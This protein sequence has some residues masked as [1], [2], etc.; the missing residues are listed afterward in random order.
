[1]SVAVNNW[2]S[3]NFNIKVFPSKKDL[4]DIAQ[5]AIE[6][7][8]KNIKRKGRKL[9][10]SSEVDSF[11]LD[12]MLNEKFYEDSETLNEAMIFFDKLVAETDMGGAFK[13]EEKNTN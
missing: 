3:Y 12:N 10:Y 13:K 7:N 9:N 4:I 5:K 11:D 6:F 8:D 1:M 2:S